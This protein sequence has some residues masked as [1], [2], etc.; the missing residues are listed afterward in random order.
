MLLKNCLL[1]LDELGL[2]Q[3]IST[4][5]HNKGRT[6]DLLLTNS[7]PLIS[8]VCVSSDK[9]IC[10]SD[11]CTITFEIKT[12]VKYKN[13]P[14]TKILNFKKANWDALNHDLRYIQWKALLDCKEPEIAWTTFKFNLFNHIKKYIPLITVKSNFTSPWFDSECFSAYRDKERSHKKYKENKTIPNELAFKSKR[15]VFKNVCSQKMRDNL[16]N[17]DDPE[18]IMKKFWSHVKSN[19]KSTRL[20]ECMHLNSRYRNNPLDKAELFN[21]YFYEQFSEASSYNIDINWSNDQ[22]FDIDFSH[23][24]IRKLLLK[25]NENKACGPDEIHG[26]ILKNCAVSLAYPL[27]ILFKNSYNTGSIPQEWKTANVIPVHKK[28]SKDDVENYRPI[29]LTC[30]IMKTFERILKE[31]LLAKTNHL[32]DSHQ[33]GFLKQKSCTI[34]MIVFT[35]NIVMSLNDYKTMS[36]DVVYFDF[37][38]AFES[39]NHDIILHKLKYFYGSNSL[40]T[41]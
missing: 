30:L 9:E 27:S 20:P 13:V 7:K 25:I 11:H 33:H 26:K 22:Q 40:K 8:N 10:K 35:D 32:L 1:T 6:L 15:H 23:Q 39:V 28:G 24:R 19:S 37:S 38:K 34:N 2:S 12:N 21:S 3:C 31:E 5:T 29:S 18:L 16:Y 17:H 36:T 4:P 41:T 14:K